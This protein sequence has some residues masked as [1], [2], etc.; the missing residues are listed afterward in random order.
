MQLEDYFEFNEFGEI[1]IQGHRIYVHDIVTAYWAG[2]K[3]AEQ[4][5]EW[6]PSLDESKIYASLLYYHLHR[7]HVDRYLQDLKAHREVMIAKQ[8]IELAPLIERMRRFAQSMHKNDVR[9]D[10]VVANTNSLGMDS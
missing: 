2:A 4:L 6:Y 9:P 5:L 10:F 3:S 7:E 8:R 1:R